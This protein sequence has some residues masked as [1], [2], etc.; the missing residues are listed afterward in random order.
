M[1]TNDTFDEYPVRRP[2]DAVADMAKALAGSTFPGGSA[3]ATLIRT[4]HDRRLEAFHRRTLN[5]LQTLEETNASTLLQRAKDGDEDATE[6]VLSTY[7]TISR[8]V[9]EAMGESKRQALAAAMA[10]SLM[11]PDGAEVERRYFLRCL[12]EFDTIHIDLIACAKQGVGAV[13]DVVN[14]HG[15]L[16]ENAKA[17]WKELNDRG[18]VNIESV[19]TMMTASGT[20]ADR[21]TPLGTRFLEFIGRR[22]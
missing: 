14:A 9:Q 4:S 17:A 20:G 6:E 8:L 11:S 18:M 5:R 10:S 12:S 13:R 2:V 1:P 22:D 21:T 19:N 16:G 3:L 7:A 15:I